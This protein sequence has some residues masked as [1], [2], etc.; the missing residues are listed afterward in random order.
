MIIGT[1]MSN[2]PI[3]ILCEDGRM[4]IPLVVPAPRSVIGPAPLVRVRLKEIP[5]LLT[6]DEHLESERFRLRITEEHERGLREKM[7]KVVNEILSFQKL[8]MKAERRSFRPEKRKIKP[9]KCFTR[10]VS[11]RC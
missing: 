7:R 6:L 10:K 1:G 9:I 2:Q 4:S 5:E 8:S 11:R 3:S